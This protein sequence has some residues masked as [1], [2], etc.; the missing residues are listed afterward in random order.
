MKS[1]SRKDGSK[2]YQP[3]VAGLTD[4]DGRPLQAGSLDPRKLTPPKNWESAIQPPKAQ[5]AEKPPKS[6]GG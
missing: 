1:D 6:Q 5:E 3:S 4:R 2:G